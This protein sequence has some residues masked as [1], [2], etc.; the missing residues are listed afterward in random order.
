MCRGE[1]VINESEQWLDDTTLAS[2]LPSPRSGRIGERGAMKQFQKQM[3]WE[4]ERPREPLW[5]RVFLTTSSRGRSPSLFFT[6]PGDW[7]VR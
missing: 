6:A 5:V 4:G 7:G 3:V 2:L 1:K